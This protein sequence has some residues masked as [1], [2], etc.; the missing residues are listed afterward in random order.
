VLPLLLLLLLLMM[1]CAPSRHRVRPA[2][3]TDLPATVDSVDRVSA[4]LVPEIP[5]RACRVPGQSSQCS[6]SWTVGVS[7]V[8][9]LLLLLVVVVV[10]VVTCDDGQSQRA[11]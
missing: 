11:V 5:S 9:R 3:A 8:V 7:C 1:A 10:V 4:S 2:S 6:T